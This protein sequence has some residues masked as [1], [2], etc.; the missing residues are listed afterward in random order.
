MDPIERMMWKELARSWLIPRSVKE[1]V[2][3]EWARGRPGVGIA[4]LA[5]F[6]CAAMAFAVAVTVKFS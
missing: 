6:Q 5:V 4:I 1:A 2:A 3:F